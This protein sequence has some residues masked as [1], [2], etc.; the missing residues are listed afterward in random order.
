[1]LPVLLLS[2]C[3]A[4]QEGL[5]K[6]EI[7]AQLNDPAGFFPQDVLEGGDDGSG[8]NAIAGAGGGSGGRGLE[9]ED[10]KVP[11]IND[12]YAQDDLPIEDTD[13]LTADMLME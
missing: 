10:F 12:L 13:V 4:I 1:M 6:Q 7:F 5:F 3:P 2:A 11:N 9:A 8:D